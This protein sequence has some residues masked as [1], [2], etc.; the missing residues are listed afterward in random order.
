M[1]DIDPLKALVWASVLGFSCGAWSALF[2][3]IYAIGKAIGA[4]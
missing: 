3:L 2:A 4:L 1:K